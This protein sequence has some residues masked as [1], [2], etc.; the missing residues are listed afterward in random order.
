MTPAG[1]TRTPLMEE[2]AR[3]AAS[4]GAG[5]Q[6]RDLLVVDAT[7]GQNAVKQ[8]QTFGGGAVTGVGDQARRHGTRRRCRGGG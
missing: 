1:H 3:S 4:S 7:T 2:R 5:A 8:A 6:A